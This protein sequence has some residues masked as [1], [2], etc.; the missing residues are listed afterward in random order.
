M[1]RFPM[2]AHKTFAPEAISVSQARAFTRRTLEGWG[3]EEL[4]DSA[5]LIVSELVTNAVVHTGTPARLALWLQGHDLR[6]E[7][8]DRHP[9]RFLPFTADQAPATAEHGRGLL[10]TTSLST[11]WGVEYTPTAKRVWAFFSNDDAPPVPETPRGVHRSD[12]SGKSWRRVVGVQ[13]CPTALF[14]SDGAPREAPP[15]VHRSGGAAHVAVVEVATDGTVT[16]W[17]A[18]ATTMFGWAAEEAVGRAYVDLVDPAG[19]GA[20]PEDLG[21]PAGPGSWQGTY[22]VLCSDGTGAPVFASHRRA[23]DP[24]GTIAL[25][26]AEEQRAL[27]EPPAPAA[28]VVIAGSTS[29]GLRDEALVRLG[30]QEYLALAAERARDPMAADATYV[31]LAHDFDDDLE[32]VAVSGLPE[33]LLGSRWWCPTS[34]TSTYPCWPAPTCARWWSCR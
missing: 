33:G 5:S 1:T 7:V 14:A 10:I 34:R 12:D 22:T 9:S 6:I 3:A 25:L 19:G 16:T 20:P 32:V 30:A 23:V 8:E 17:N 15:G 4:V 24:D 28:P 27:L 18:D 21:V 29:P 31:L 26:V 13:G 2:R 11:T